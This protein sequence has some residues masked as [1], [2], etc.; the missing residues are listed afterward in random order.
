MDSKWETPLDHLL[1]SDEWKIDCT[2]QAARGQAGRGG[3][4]LAP[5][6]GKVHLAGDGEIIQGRMWDRAAGGRGGSGNQRGN[7]CYAP[8]MVTTPPVGGMGVSYH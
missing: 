3:R 7:I 1:G 8:L 6:H 4:K 5:T 2:V